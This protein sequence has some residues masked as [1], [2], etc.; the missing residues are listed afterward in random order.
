MA[1]RLKPVGK[2]KIENQYG[3]RFTDAEKRQLVSLVNSATRKR[4]RMLQEE[5]NIPKMAGTEKTNMSVKEYNN[6][7]GKESDFILAKKTKSL[8][9]FETKSAYNKYIKN[10]KKVVQTDYIEK[11]TEQY[12]KNY[13]KAM[14]Q[15]IAEADPKLAKAVVKKLKEMSNKEYQKKVAGNESLEISYH[16]VPNEKFKKL[17]NVAKA[18]MTEEEINAV[19]APKARKKR[20][21]NLSTSDRYQGSKIF[22]GWNN[23]L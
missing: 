12:K 14:K 16:Y 17:N 23:D 3:V 6:F 1:K 11:R 7:M 20:K 2:N 9:R 8:Q 18:V 15:N 21:N 10:L 4:S 13:I 5:A 19:K 22:S